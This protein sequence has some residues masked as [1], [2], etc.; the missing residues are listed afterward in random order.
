MGEKVHKK[1]KKGLEL[2]ID[3]SRRGGS[4][5]G[6][7]LV[8]LSIDDRLWLVQ[9]IPLR[10]KADLIISSPDPMALLK[11]LSPQEVYLIVRESWGDDASVI[12][13]MTPP[14]KIVQ[15]MDIDIWRRDRVDYK[16]F[17]EWLELV[18]VGGERALVKS[19]FCL[20]PPLLVLFFKGIIEVT[21]RNLDQDPLEMSDG[22][23][24]SFD[25]IY[26]FRPVNPDLNFDIIIS[27]LST[28]FEIEPEFYKIIMEGIMG[29]LPS[30]TEEEAYQLRSSRMAASGF[31]EFY[32]AREILLYKDTEALKSEIKNGTGKVIYNEE[33]SRDE[34]PPNYWLM[35][36]DGEG[37]ILE[38]L[39][40]E[41]GGPRDDGVILWE[42]SYLVHKLVAAEG[43]DLAD[44]Q[45]IVSSVEMAK[46]YLNLGLEILTDG[47]RDEGRRVLKAV[48]LQSVFSLGYSRALEVKKSLERILKRL[49]GLIDPAFWGGEAND[50]IDSLSGVRPFFYEGIAKGLDQY[51]NFRSI[52]DVDLV[53]RFLTELELK[54][55]MVSSFVN[56]PVE[57]ESYLAKN[58]PVNNWGIDTIFTTAF[59]RR[60]LNGTWE[61]IPLS[62]KDIERF[63]KALKAKERK[64]EEAKEETDEII[65]ELLKK[66][67]GEGRA[68]LLKGFVSEAYKGLEDELSAIKDKKEIDPR[69]IGSVITAGPWS[70]SE[71][72]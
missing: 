17:M 38:E 69:F 58:A 9:R 67:A 16:R 27:V 28:F 36:T 39:L 54:V 18:A 46:D 45:Q 61:V 57:I 48:Y 43:S 10:K 19:L 55:E 34:L 2:L 65:G 53:E 32:E 37:G 71:I 22:G 64:I 59:V 50:L 52:R 25:S 70:E 56:I 11:K 62:Q 26:Y 14:E 51:R 42:L 72:V 60:C 41:M 20:D 15:L 5:D 68:D 23:F 8:E 31:P 3:R 1:G 40:A 21:S 29:E 49:R 7:D 47:N 6:S 13:E 33:V 24:Y 44:T 63:Y 12:L 30:P 35:T 66:G 4:I